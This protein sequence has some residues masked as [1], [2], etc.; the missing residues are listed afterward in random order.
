[1]LDGKV[2]G[3]CKSIAPTAEG[4]AI[5]LGLIKLSDLHSIQ[6]SDNPPLAVDGYAAQLALPDWMLPLP[7]PAK[8]DS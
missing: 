3:T 1:M 6:Q 5:A 4:G 7:T 8:T 2:I